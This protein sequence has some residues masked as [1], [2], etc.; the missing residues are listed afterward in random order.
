MSVA[1]VTTPASTAAPTLMEATCAAVQE[2]SS[3]P[4]KGEEHTRDRNNKCGVYHRGEN[5]GKVVVLHF[6]M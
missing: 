4:D 6:D 5:T 2:G 3:E 1:R